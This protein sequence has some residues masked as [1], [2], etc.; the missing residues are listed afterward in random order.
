MMDDDASA[1]RRDVMTRG[2]TAESATERL[3]SP[4]RDASSTSRGDIARDVRGSRVVAM[5]DDASA[6]KTG[7]D[8]EDAPESATERLS[9]P[10]RGLK[11]IVRRHRAR[12]CARDRARR[13]VARTRADPS[14]EY[15]V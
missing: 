9:S 2:R 1:T 15:I 10:A 3:S 7:C 14:D 8:D 5:D 12:M 6:T 13:G 11:H 4:A